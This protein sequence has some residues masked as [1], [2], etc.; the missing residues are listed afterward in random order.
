MSKF[1]NFKRNVETAGMSEIQTAVFKAT[2][3]DK[4]PPK[5]KHVLFLLEQLATSAPTV[6]PELDAELA[7]RLRSCRS[8]KQTL[9]AAKAIA[10]V[11]RLVLAGGGASLPECGAELPGVCSAP[12]GDPMLRAQA[13]A[14]ADAA[15]YVR[16][17]RE[18]PEAAALR[19]HGG[20]Q[21]WRTRPIHLVTAGLPRM[22]RLLAQALECAGRGP[23]ATASLQALRCAV[24]EDALCLF[25]RECA[26]VAVL[27][28]NLLTL[29]PALV[30][31]SPGGA[32]EMLDSF[33]RHAARA[34]ALQQALSAEARRGGDA[35]AGL[36]RLLA[37]R[38]LW[39]SA[40][41]WAAA[42][43]MP[44]A[45][46]APAAAPAP[47]PA[48]E[49]GGGYFAGG[50][51]D[52]DDGGNTVALLARM[53]EER[54][55]LV[56]Y[57]L[58]QLPEESLCALGEAE[59]GRPIRTAIE[60]SDDELRRLR[61]D[62][63]LRAT[64]QAAGARHHKHGAAI[65]LR[66]Q[67]T[68][69]IAELTPRALVAGG[70]C[71][72]SAGGGEASPG[73]TFGAQTRSPS[74]SLL[75]YP[76]MMSPS[77]TG[78]SAPSTP[79]GEMLV[80]PPLPVPKTELHPQLVSRMSD[81]ALSCAAYETLYLAVLAGSAAP[82]AAAAD[83]LQAVRARLNLTKRQEKRLL[84]LLRPTGW[85]SGIPADF[86][87]GAEAV[88]SPAYRGLLLLHAGE[89]SS[90]VFGDA[91]ASK[92]PSKTAAAAKRER[93]AWLKELRDFGARQCALLCNAHAAGDGAAPVLL[94]LR[95][96]TERLLKLRAGSAQAADATAEGEGRA[97]AAAE[98][99]IK[100]EAAALREALG[101]LHATSALAPRW[102]VALGFRLYCALLEATFEADE[103][104]ELASDRGAV[105]ALLARTWPALGVDAASHE[106]AD[107]TVLF[108]HYQ[109]CGAPQLLPL[110]LN[111]LDAVEARPPAPSAPP[112]APAPPPASNNPFDEAPEAASG[113]VCRPDERLVEDVGEFVGRRRT[114]VLAGI[115]SYI[116]GKLRD[117]RGWFGC[118]PDELKACVELWRRCFLALD[119]LPAGAPPLV[120]SDSVT[121]AL[122][123]L[124]GSG[125][126]AQREVR[127]AAKAAAE[128]QV[129]AE[130]LVEA[131]VSRHLK[132][133]RT[134][135][136]GAGRE[137][138]NPY[139]ALPAEDA[140]A[141][142][143]ERRL[144]ELA[145]ALSDELDVEADFASAFDSCFRRDA[146]GGGGGGGK[147]LAFALGVVA[148][149]VEIDLAAALSS[150][151][152]IDRGSI[153][154]VEAFV[155][156]QKKLGDLAAAAAAKGGGKVAV[157]A[158][159]AAAASAAALPSLGALREQ[160]ALGWCAQLQEVLQTNLG[161]ALRLEQWAVVYEGAP[162][163]SSA[164]DVLKQLDEISQVRDRTR[165]RHRGRRT[166]HASSSPRSS[167]YR[168][169]SRLPS[170]SR[171]RPP[172]S[173]ASSTC[174]RCSCRSTC[175]RSTP[176]A[177]RSP[178]RRCSRASTPPPRRRHRRPPRSSRRARRLPSASSTSGRTRAPPPRRTR[179]P[180]PTAGRGRWR[181]TRRSTRSR[182]AS[183]ASA[184]TT[185]SGS[186]T[187]RSRSPTGCATSSPASPRCRRRR[188]GCSSPSPTCATARASTSSITSRR[189]SSSTSST[190]TCS[191]SCTRRRPTPTARGWRRCSA[192]RRSRPRRRGAPCRGGGSRKC[193]WGC[194][195]RSPPR[196]PPCSSCRRA[197]T[198][199]A[200]CRSS[201]RTSGCSA[202]TS[203]TAACSRSRSSASRSDS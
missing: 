167:L 144:V 36:D 9:V 58:K 203:S 135:I 78:G 52:D 8:P 27:Q 133:L 123:A 162:C 121:L 196:T 118:D 149:E 199:V 122:A 57:L 28:D 64:R 14:V 172:R 87:R 198:G 105:L 202:A 171:S 70:S 110:I 179:A 170:C 108:D 155:A 186:A 75:L 141:A 192:R 194:W 153:A 11:H 180:P 178:S 193:C 38:L 19:T 166:A 67:P 120:A 117:Y 175:S 1:T 48:G 96:N 34:L 89:S 114:A 140:V 182:S 45:A 18:W 59:V 32:L 29:R 191:Q 157:G 113:A 116:G 20:A 169:S 46:T 189:R 156:L 124:P 200:T 73:G 79:R 47:A 147:G 25:R 66:K 88:A 83:A 84:P 17:L 148:R 51:D 185:P 145:T 188:A 136:E 81:D 126:R 90:L 31:A 183:C 111:A 39:P 190:P 184:S 50:A 60:L 106:L 42:P 128:L 82:P 10:V 158:K 109:Q 160:A 119:A 129:Q 92:T 13:D 53:E 16:Q 85:H 55:E 71:G 142:E 43:P 6:A 76:S 5:E 143:L 137:A 30:G 154:V 77:Y 159:A 104:A 131:S 74:V 3:A 93:D 165:L 177:R 80:L 102:P 21:Q 103:P 24:A 4:L 164:V 146:S 44:P 33:S 127:V 22:Q 197:R 101:E 150:F 112:P 173:S 152:T 125:D 63:L 168:S 161:E 100:R 115:V 98:D 56:L 134:A 23:S 163:S 69:T 37:E 132:R 12:E 41:P 35:A 62:A 151:P 97:D 91:D 201:A 181:A 99:A 65:N 95:D 130:A 195:A 54:D 49:D 26:A 174:W 86:L 187:R 7:K 61:T 138:D 2:T 107:L 40:V 72:T 15:D 139:D 68:L 176:S 94:R